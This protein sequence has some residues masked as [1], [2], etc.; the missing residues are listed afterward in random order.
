MLLEGNEDYTIAEVVIHKFEKKELVSFIGDVLIKKYKTENPE[1]QSMWSSDVARLAYMIRELTADNEPSWYTDKG[2]VKTAKYTVKPILLHIKED[3][4]RIINESREALINTEYDDLTSSKSDELRKNILI[5]S[6][7]LKVI[8]KG[9]LSKE[10]IKYIASHF[11]LDRKI[12]Q[13]KLTYD[14]LGEDELVD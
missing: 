6:E 7:I 11:S 13:K 9:E 2:G 14:A 4:T 10:V 5:G 1:D 3:L 12:N 8:A